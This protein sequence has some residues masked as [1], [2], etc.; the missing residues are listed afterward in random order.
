MTDDDRI[1]RIVS[2]LCSESGSHDYTIN[3]REAR[4][5]GL[6]VET[7]SMGFYGVMKA[8]H[9]DLRVELQLGQAFDPEMMLVGAAPGQPA[10]S[11]QVPYSATRAFIESVDG[12]SH[13]FVSEGILTRAM[14]DTP[15]GQMLGVLNQKK[16]EGWRHDP[17]V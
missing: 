11:P 8:L 15:A 1:I 6:D 12:G 4:E 13:R 7:P 5:I 2:T 10:Q 17:A 3:R 16:A 14:V 9:D